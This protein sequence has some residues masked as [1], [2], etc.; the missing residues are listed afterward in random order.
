M[1]APSKHNPLL[2][3]WDIVRDQGLRSLIDHIVPSWLPS[4]HALLQSDLNT[5]KDVQRWLITR[6]SYDV[7][8]FDIFDTL[9]RRRIDPPE[10]VKLLVSRHISDLLARYG[11]NVGPEEILAQRN[12]A[13]EDL[14]Y[15]A[16]LSGKDGQC[17]LA[18]IMKRTLSDMKVAD[19]LDSKDIV[20]YELTL[21]KKATE[22]M[23]RAI[24]ILTYLKSCGR[25][26]VGVS[27]TYL[28][29]NQIAGL[30]KHHGLVQYIDKLYV[31]SDIGK[32][33]PSGK[34]FQHI[35]E[36]E[37]TRIAHI[38]D[39]YQL[40]NIVPR[41][42]GITTLWFHSRRE[43]LRKSELSK[44]RDGSNKLDYVNAVIRSIDRD[45]SKF[46]L[47]GYEVLG[48]ALTVFV[49]NV[50]GQARKDDVEML[51]FVA[52]DGYAMKKIYEILRESMY[53][54]C[55]LP[56]AKY[57]C[58]G[59]APVRLA[60]LGKLTCS[61]IS[62]I[63][64]Y[65]IRSGKRGITLRDV[66]GSYGLD[67]GDF[68]G[69]VNQHQIDFDEV[70]ADPVQ[71]SRLQ[72][73]LQG[74]EFSNVIQ[75]KSDEVKKLLRDYLV[76]IEFMGRQRVAFV[77]GQS[78]GLTKSLLEHAFGDDKGYPITYGYY[79]NLLNLGAHKADVNVESSQVKGI[80]NDW[81][82]GTQ[83][84]FLKIGALLEIFAHPN[85]G[86]TVGYKK[87]NGKTVPIF[88]RTPQENQYAITSQGLQGILAYARDYSVYY[89]LHNYSPE[90]LLEHLKTNIR[91]WVQHLPRRHAL[92]LRNLFLTSDWPYQVNYPLAKRI[93]VLDIIKIWQLR[94][95][96]ALSNWPELTLMS[97]PSSTLLA[98]KVINFNVRNFVNLRL[99]ALLR[100]LRHL[101]GR[102][103]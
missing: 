30:L 33:K 25:R 31:S 21:E 5:M 92:A 13:E 84:P 81:R 18:D 102:Q 26:V 16:N 60:S 76:T 8:S 27:E 89:R 51:F 50:V 85:H 91:D 68:I 95:K 41:R 45:R 63:R 7:Y 44:L 47:V 20:D 79:F 80:V 66:L 77:D 58:L 54:G 61:E 6:R 29:L 75:A 46:Y 42:L 23:P 97:A 94:R 11:I 71:N 12:K 83:I 86:V 72:E 96:V 78:E 37:G 93:N 9:L 82:M 10:L 53:A 88:R 32:G 24:D 57:M 90:D 22:P 48:P 1:K 69:T 73:I 62:E 15:Q 43:L 36:N 35:I 87:V 52:R 38:G 40:D 56:P 49:H 98:Y 70:I 14:R 4:I 39:N 55:N 17:H 101:T 103:G 99:G 74:K 67:S 34:L 59:R 28:S 19:V 65:M 64:A 3:A 100:L 2:R